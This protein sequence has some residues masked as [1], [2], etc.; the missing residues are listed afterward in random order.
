MGTEKDNAALVTPSISL[1]DS[2]SHEPKSTES[3]CTKQSLFVHLPS[4]IIEADQVIRENNQDASAKPAA[5]KCRHKTFMKVC[6]YGI[7]W[8]FQ[9][10]LA[11]LSI[12]KCFIMKKVD[13]ILIF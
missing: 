9:C 8:K 10:I 4:C 7:V 11:S 6:K 1:A 5:D 13:K 12:V 2:E 3:P